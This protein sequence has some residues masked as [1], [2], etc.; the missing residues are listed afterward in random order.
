MQQAANLIKSR[1]NILIMTHKNPDGDAIGSVLGLAHG[2][3][4][5]G[6]KVECFSKDTIPK[7]FDFLPNVSKI[8][9]QTIYEKY[10]LVILLDCAF[11]DRTGIENIKEITSSFSDI[12]IIDHHPKDKTGCDYYKKCIFII[13]PKASSTAV[14]IYELLKK[15]GIKIT[16][17]I[18]NCLLT[19]IFTDT[20]GF[21]HD[22]TDSKSLKAAAEFMKKGSRVDKIT[23]N[24]FSNKSMAAIKLWGIA[25]S[26]I[27]T[28]PETGMAVSYVSKKDIED[29]GAKEEDLS[30]L[31]NVINTI[32]DAKFSLLL[33]ESGNNK[34]KGSLR[35]E[36]YK[37]IDVSKIAR[38]LGGGGHKLASGFEFD[39]DLQN[40][41]AKISEIILKSN[42]DINYGL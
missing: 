25:L 1:E 29:F 8:K 13:D 41:I 39:G 24:I 33:T 19:G 14:L 20:G 17:D 15:T 9:N 36:N 5:L 7:I 26:R 23:K 6:K 32:S 37:G 16:K 2:L 4:S 3:E 28:D 22:N 27:K 35:S 10:E 30:G 31:V 11:F 12:L 40:N 34:I 18:A 38:S 21:Q 42:Q